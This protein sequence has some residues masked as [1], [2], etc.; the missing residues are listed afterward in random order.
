VARAS[1]KLTRKR[2]P[3]LD[4]AGD[5]NRLKAWVARHWTLPIME[6]ENGS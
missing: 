1:P 3:P 5:R 4:L 2:G 6:S